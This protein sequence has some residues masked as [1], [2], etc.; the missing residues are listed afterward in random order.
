M[1]V[2]TDRGVWESVEV[3]DGLY[4]G[5]CLSGAFVGLAIDILVGRAAQL[6]AEGS[7]QCQLAVFMDDTVVAAP[8]TDFA[9][10]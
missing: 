4:Q 2:E 6:L 3:C 5:E 7:R 9:Y 10:L 8:P 1:W